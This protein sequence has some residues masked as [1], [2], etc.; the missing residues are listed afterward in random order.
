[1]HQEEN[2][3]Q[4]EYKLK[5]N[6]EQLLWRSSSIEEQHSDVGARYLIKNAD[7]NM[8]LCVLNSMDDK[9]ARSR[10]ESG[11]SLSTEGDKFKLMTKK[12]KVRIVNIR[13][14]MR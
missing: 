8:V 6:L 13:I 4:E 3:Y 10:L 1:M 11:L 5:E 7:I 9:A 12:P 14:F 2:N